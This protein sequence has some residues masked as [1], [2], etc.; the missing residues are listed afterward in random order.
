MFIYYFFGPKS[1]EE[2][3]TLILIFAKNDE[4]ALEILNEECEKE[5]VRLTAEDFD[6]QTITALPDNESA[7]LIN[8]TAENGFDFKTVINNWNVRFCSFL[9]I[10]PPTPGSQG[11]FSF[12]VGGLQGTM[13]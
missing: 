3:N 13:L 11:G 6:L 1:A 9:V 5:T 7:L 12:W 8:F 10:Q 4:D 2:P